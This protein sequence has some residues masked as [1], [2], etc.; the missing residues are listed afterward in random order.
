MAGAPSDAAGVTGASGAP[1]DLARLAAFGVLGLY[2]LSSAFFLISA[3]LFD[4]ARARPARSAESIAVGP[5]SDWLVDHG[6]IAIPDGLY[7]P[8]VQARFVTAAGTLPITGMQYFTD[9]ALWLR[10][11]VPTIAADDLERTIRISDPRVRRAWLVWR[12]GGRIEMRSWSFDGPERL[13]GFGSRTPSFH[14]AAGEMEGQEVHIGFTSLSVQRGA[15]FFETRRAYAAWELSQSVMPA[16]LGG[17][18]VSIGLYLLVG[19]AFSRDPAQLWASVMSFALFCVIVGGA[20]LFHAYLLPARPSLADFLAYMPRPLVLSAWL[21]F[22]AVYLQLRTR[23]PWVFVL[24]SAIALLVPFQ[25]SLAALKV[26]LDIDTPLA[27]TSSGPSI[28]G[29]A[30]GLGTLA[31]FAWRGSR[32]ARLALLCWLPLVLGVIVR[33]VVI[34]FPGVFPP[35]FLN[36]DP[37]ADVVVSMIALS[38]VLVLDSQARERA[39]RLRAEA[40]EQRLREFSEIASHSFFELAPDRTLTSTTGPLAEE[41]GIVAGSTLGVLDGRLESG[42]RSLLQFADEVMASGRGVREAEFFSR[43]D[44]GRQRWYSF[45]M[46]PWRDEDG[47]LAGIRGTIEDA[48]TRVE[49]RARVAQQGKLAA[50]GQLAGGIAHEVNNLLH[51]VINLARRVRDNHVDDREGRRLLEI[52]IDSGKRAGEVVEGVLDSVSST[53]R[54]GPIL[55]LSIAVERAVAASVALLPPAIRFSSEIEPLAHPPLPFGEMLQVVGNLVQNARQ[56]IVDQ[57]EVVVS[58][59]AEGDSAVLT[60]KDDGAGMSEDVRRTAFEPFVTS[61]ADGTGLGLSSVASIV[62]GWGGSVEIRSLEGKGTSVIVR[63]LKGDRIDEQ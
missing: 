23:A 5:T 2:L 6:T 24:L 58:L 13:S 39:L 47:T 46:E 10:F 32:R 34:A 19:G 50:M 45:N 55:P 38:A 26:G 36:Y 3:V 63:I 40:N 4:A 14:F 43:D 30:A 15:V 33:S 49:R 11:T 48:T 29:F 44:A 42:G 18:L 51:P 41:L 56:A 37:L 9:G 25:A 8:A 62:A 12:E 60:V 52:V 57:G 31:V 20:G 17:A 16:L 54:R 28:L 61:R 35:N 21:M 22:V 59:A 53:R 1:R 7:E 27:I